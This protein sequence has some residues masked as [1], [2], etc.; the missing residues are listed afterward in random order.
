MGMLALRT[1]AIRIA[2]MIF[3]LLEEN[4]ISQCLNLS[5]SPRNLP[6]VLVHDLFGLRWMNSNTKQF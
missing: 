6:F 3:S 5:Q 1:Q 2:P 4:P